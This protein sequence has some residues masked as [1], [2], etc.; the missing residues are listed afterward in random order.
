MAESRARNGRVSLDHLV[1]EVR[2]CSK[3]DRH[4]SQLERAPTG[5]IWDN[6]NIKIS[7]DGNGL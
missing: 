7:N 5:Q 1:P 3:N 4:G 6:M 2:I